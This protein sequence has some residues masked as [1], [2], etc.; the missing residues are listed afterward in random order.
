MVLG[1][2]STSPSLTTWDTERI[3]VLLSRPEAQDWGHEVSRRGESTSSVSL[4]FKM[5]LPPSTNL[6]FSGLVAKHGSQRTCENTNQVKSLTC[7]VPPGHHVSLRVIASIFT[8]HSRPCTLWACSSVI[9]S[10]PLSPS[11]TQPQPH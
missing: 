6:S 11:L 8:V 7:S 9:P 4:P 1:C 3:P 10:F 5:F 2:L